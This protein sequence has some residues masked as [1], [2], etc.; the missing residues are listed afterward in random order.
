MSVW[1][2]LYKNNTHFHCYWIPIKQ[3]IWLS[4]H[5]V[6]LCID[7]GKVESHSASTQYAADKIS[8]CR[9]K[10]AHC[11]T[12]VA[13][14]GVLS[15]L[16]PLPTLSSL[17]PSPSPLEC[18]VR[19]GA[20]MGGDGSA[21]G[22]RRQWSNTSYLTATPPAAGRPLPPLHS[23][24]SLPPGGILQ[25]PGQR[26]LG[27]GPSR[28]A[29]RQKEDFVMAALTNA[30]H[31][32]PQI[33]TSPLPSAQPASTPQLA[34]PLPA[35]LPQPA[36]STWKC[37]KTF[38]EATRASRQTAV[39]AKKRQVQQLNGWFSRPLPSLHSISAFKPT[40][41]SES[42][43]TTTAVGQTAG[44]SDVGALTIS[45][46]APWASIITLL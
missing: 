40:R 11:H 27:E 6:S 26:G 4:R 46:H 24:T 10:L 42:P 33:V 16:F 14:G 39:L 31:T 13:R 28:C 45:F 1:C 41:H 36:L 35:L 32:A 15:P 12:L 22:G 5:G 18:A 44:A 7:P 30:R 29:W 2:D 19:V 8:Q 34:P 23:V 3:S 43:C 25:V 37:T 20:K 9:V 21:I 17:Q 38:S